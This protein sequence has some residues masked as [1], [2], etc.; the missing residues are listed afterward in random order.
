MATTQRINPSCKSSNRLKVQSREG[1]IHRVIQ[2]GVRAQKTVQGKNPKQ[3]K[4]HP[5]G[6][7]GQKPTQ[8][9]FDMPAEIKQKF[10][11]SLESLVPK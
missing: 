6:K 7:Q 8:N 1:Q 11:P 9:H 4:S 10:T 3:E 2:A 5:K